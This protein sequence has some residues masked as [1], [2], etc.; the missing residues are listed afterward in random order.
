MKI[1]FLGTSSMIP[2]KTRNHSATFIQHEKEGILV[3]CGEGTQRQFRLASISPSKV[4]KLLISH[5]H[6]DHVLGIPGLLQNL[7]ANNY[8]K[9]LEIYGP[10]GSK[11]RLKHMLEGIEMAGI[12]DYKLKEV[13][14]G[15]ICEEKDF[16]IE[17]KKLN[18]QFYTSSGRTV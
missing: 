17:T 15:T 3:D 6:G 10:K 12:I 1:T 5:W 18:Q 11:T 2:T 4:T 9:T 8:K 16:S 13:T 14:S 7:K